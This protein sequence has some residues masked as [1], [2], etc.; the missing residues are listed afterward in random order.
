M[1]ELSFDEIKDWRQ[2]EELT[3]A[4]FRYLKDSPANSVVDVQVMRSGVGI[5][6]G[7]DIIVEIVCND[8]IRSFARKWVVQ[9]KFTKKAV[10]STD[11]SQVNLPTLLSSQGAC[12]Y[13][14]VC[15][16]APTTGL[17]TLF[18]NLKSQN[19]D[20]FFEI[21][22]GEEFRS[23]LILSPPVILQQYFPDFWMSLQQIAKTTNI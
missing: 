18:K 17:T 6:D 14:L 2:F 1:P 23:K 15:K 7:V 13:L 11:I 16:E 19:S 4:Y 12:G 8:G 9:C 22:S 5:D 3:A 20:N 21:W 10:S